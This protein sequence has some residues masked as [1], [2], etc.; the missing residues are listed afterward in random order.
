MTAGVRFMLL[1]IVKIGNS[2]GIRLPAVI[3]KE[4]NIS[5]KVN[6]EVVDGVIVISPVKSPRT[7]W[8][9]AFKKMHAAGEDIMQIT[10]EKIEEPEDWEW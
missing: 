2:R 10:A 3:I 6:M 1:D 9:K 7:G 5:N 8:D 4:C